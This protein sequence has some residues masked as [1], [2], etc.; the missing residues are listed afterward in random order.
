VNAVR[1]HKYG[2]GSGWAGIL[3]EGSNTEFDAEKLDRMDYFV[4]ELKKR[5]IFVKLSNTFGSMKLAQDGW[6]RIAYADEWGKEP[7]GRKSLT[8]GSGAVYLSREL[9]DLHIEQMTNLLEHTNPYTGMTYA[10]DPAVMLVEMVNEESALFFGTL[11][12][13]QQVPTLKQ[14]IG[15]RFA[16]WLLERYGSEQAVTERWGEDGGLNTFTQE[17]LTDESFA[18]RRVYP[19]GNPWFWDPANLETS[20]A[21]RAPRLYDAALFLSQVQDEFYDRYAAAVRDTGYVGLLMTSNW[22]AGKAS[23]HFYNLHSDARY[24][25]IDRH[26]Y[27]GGRSSMLRVPGG[28]SLSSGMQQV[29]DRPFSL[30]EWVHVFPSQWGAEGPAVIGAYGMGLQAWDLSFMFQNRD[31]GRYSRALGADKWDVTAPQVFAPFPAIARH[32]RR[33]DIDTSDEVAFLN[34]HYDSLHRGEVGFRDD[35]RQIYDIKVFDTDQVPA[36]ALAVQP[37]DGL[38]GAL[39]ERIGH[40]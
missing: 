13:I 31:R 4:A 33:M 11:K 20:Q 8:T 23:S 10:E 16:E 17:K 37:V 9:Q 1:L 27:F 5:G 19:V 34:V 36:Q 30:S 40:G 21:A 35:T 3:A 25:V 39:L 14:R 18:E 32:V 38:R 7:R 28:G 2:D 15:E 29:V 24:D 26:N 12:Q 22:Q 6:Q